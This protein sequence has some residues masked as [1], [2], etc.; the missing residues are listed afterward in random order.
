MRACEAERLFAAMSVLQMEKPRSRKGQ[1]FA[2]SPLQISQSLER[3]DLVTI[4]L[5]D[6][7]M[8]NFT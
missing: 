5:S 8:E 4:A 7:T 2:K 3:E 1:W 6:T